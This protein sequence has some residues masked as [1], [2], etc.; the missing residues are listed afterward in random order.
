LPVTAPIPFLPFICVIALPHCFPAFASVSSVL[1]PSPSASM[2][3]PYPSGYPSYFRVSVAII[4]PAW[5]SNFL[6]PS[7]SLLVYCLY[8]HP[9]LFQALSAF[10]D[11]LNFAASD[12]RRVLPSGLSSK[13]DFPRHISSTSPRYVLPSKPDFLSQSLC[14]PVHTL[15]G[16]RRFNR[17]K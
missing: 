10:A 14:P 17:M 3:S 2:S 9:L 7:R 12:L 15:P 6:K 8:V 16:E 1:Y 4:D 13:D 11:S 5:F